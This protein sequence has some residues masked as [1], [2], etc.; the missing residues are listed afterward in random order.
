MLNNTPNKM[1]LICHT[2]KTENLSDFIQLNLEQELVEQ[3]QVLFG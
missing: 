2:D 1:Q 3:V